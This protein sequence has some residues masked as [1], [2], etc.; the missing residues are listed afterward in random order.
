MSDDNGRALTGNGHS[1][2]SGADLG[3]GAEELIAELFDDYQAGFNDYEADRISD[4]FALPVIIWQ[5]DEG[6]VFNTDEE[7]MENIE[8]LL[9][10]LDKEGVVHS[11]FHVSS[12]HISGNVALITLDWRQEN[13]DG[14]DVLEFTCH[15]HLVQNGSAWAI[16]MVVNE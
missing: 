9:S 3:G 14:E 2:G 1:N 10:A 4:C 5:H 15:Y 6:H 16:A 8:A 11:D 12:S 13:A 7:L